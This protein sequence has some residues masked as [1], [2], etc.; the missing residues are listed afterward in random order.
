VSAIGEAI[1]VAGT[2]AGASIG[3]G[4][5]LIVSRRE[6][7]HALNARMR[8]AFGVF[9]G[10]LYPAVAD[11]RELPDID[12]LPKSVTVINHL[13]GERATYVATRR[14]EREIFGDALRDRAHRVAIAVAELQV[15]PLPD[16]AREAVE[17][18]LDYLERLGRRRTPELKAEWTEIHAQ[19]ASAAELL[20]IR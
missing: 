2:L 3:V 15:L 10:A 20:R 1:A 5:T 7:Q 12:G 9:L 13:R 19:L 6:R 4:G 18:G 16:Q 17:T 8:D 11:L 14:R